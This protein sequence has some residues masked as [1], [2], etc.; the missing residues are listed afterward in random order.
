VEVL[1]DDAYSASQK[2]ISQSSSRGIPSAA[3][4]RAA[5]RRQREEERMLETGQSAKTI[6]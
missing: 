6:E 2:T 5:K 1:Q 3:E 4:A